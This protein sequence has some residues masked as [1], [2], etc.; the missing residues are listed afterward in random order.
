MSSWSDHQSNKQPPCNQMYWQVSYWGVPRKTTCLFPSVK[1][2]FTANI[3]ERDSLCSNELSS[4]VEKKNHPRVKSKLCTYAREIPCCLNQKSFIVVFLREAFICKMTL[5]YL[6]W[7]YL[8]IS[9]EQLKQ[10][11]ERTY[12]VLFSSE[13]V[14][15]QS[16]HWCRDTTTQQLLKAVNYGREWQAAPELANL[17]FHSKEF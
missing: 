11:K 2:G 15:L 9:E 1:H 5:T 7:S 13:G 16:A 8:N 17:I 10:H 12:I 3:V 14:R 6:P 4:S